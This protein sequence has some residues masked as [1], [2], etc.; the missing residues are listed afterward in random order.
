MDAGGSS[1]TN[2]VGYSH[3]VNYAYRISA[4]VYDA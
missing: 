4:S 3:S 1:S 2:Y